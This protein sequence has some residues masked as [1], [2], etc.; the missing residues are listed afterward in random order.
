M[1]NAEDRYDEAIRAT[2]AALGGRARGKAGAPPC[3]AGEPP[4]PAVV[5][6]A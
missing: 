2:L 6:G 1:V 3:A 5:L 4:G